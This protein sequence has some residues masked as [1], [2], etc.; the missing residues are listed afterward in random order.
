MG[1]AQACGGIGHCATVSQAVFVGLSHK[2]RSTV[3]QVAESD[4]VGG[5]G[6]RSGG[7]VVADRTAH[8]ATPATGGRCGTG[9]T[10]DDEPVGRINEASAR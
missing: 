1:R 5:A 7:D 2:A 10:H 9:L 4:R 3:G 8:P 6:R